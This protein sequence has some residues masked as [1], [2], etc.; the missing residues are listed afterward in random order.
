MESSNS[1][2]SQ[3]ERVSG[4]NID[5][6]SPQLF[7]PGKQMLTATITARA[8]TRQKKKFTTN[9]SVSTL[10]LRIASHK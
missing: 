4:S 6:L 10:T 7:L 1:Q 8:L 3:V 2:A 9:D 5:R